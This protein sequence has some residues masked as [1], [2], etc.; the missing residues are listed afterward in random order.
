MDKTIIRLLLIL[1]MIPRFPR[2]IDSKIICSKLQVEYG[3]EVDIRT[4]QRDMYKLQDANFEIECDN[5]RP[6]GWSWRKDAQLVEFPHMNPATA[7]AFRMTEQY[8]ARMFPQGAMSVLKP[9]FKA[10]RGLAP[11]QTGS[12][13]TTWPDKIKVVS[14]SFQ[15]SPPVIS[16]GVSDTVYEALL[17]ERCL[18]SVYLTVSGKKKTFEI[19]PLGLAFVDSLIY[20][21]ATLN[22][23]HD[24]ILLLLHR[25]QEIQMIDKQAI[26]PDGFDLEEYVRR[27]LTF[28]VGK[29][30][31]LKALFT[32]S[33]DIQRIQETPIAMDQKIKA[34]Q[35]GKFEL[36]AT[37]GDTIQ[38]RWWLKGF[39]DRVEI[40][41]PEAL[42]NEFISLVQNLARIYA[43]S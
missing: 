17:E 14:R 23:H 20:L 32:N 10:A 28:P 9:Y 2:K 19:N 4:I 15:G 21:V 34:T 25:I 7:L 43:I 27:E 16:E 8:T 41:E 3:I 12:R 36:A 39:G 30:I 6:K 24:P 35:D 33:S 11:E 42:R 38:L 26:V 1:R 40:L 22:E 31:L 37:V 13:L 29:Q 18:K 5:N